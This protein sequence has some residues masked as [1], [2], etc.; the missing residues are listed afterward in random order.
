MLLKK[1]YF[2]PSPRLSITTVRGTVLSGSGRRGSLSVGTN[3]MSSKGSKSSRRAG[4]GRSEMF[5]L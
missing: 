4:V 2:A 1:A 5:W 3:V